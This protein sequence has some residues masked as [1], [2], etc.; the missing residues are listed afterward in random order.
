[1]SGPSTCSRE[2]N[3]QLDDAELALL[4][5]AVDNHDDVLISYR[6]KNG[7]HSI[8]QIRPGRIYGRWLDS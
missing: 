5:H 2:L 3:P 6:D 8:R 7:S 4:S 1:M